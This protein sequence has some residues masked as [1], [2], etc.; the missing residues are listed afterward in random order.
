MIRVISLQ[1]GSSGNSVYVEADGV[2]ILIDAGISARQAKRR[3]AEYG[4][5]VT[6]CAA[7]LI[8]HDHSDHAR[9][10]GVYHRLFGL[11]VCMT[12][13][14]Y[15]AA[16]RR[17]RLGEIGALR[18]FEAGQSL[19]L[20][21]G[22]ASLWVHSVPTPHDGAD[23]VTFVVESGQ[24]RLGIFSDLGHV[25]GE[26]REAVQSVDAMLIESNYDPDMLEA[27]RYPEEL[28]HRI[29]GPGGHLS[30][31]ESADLVAFALNRN[32]KLRWA[33]LCHLSKDNNTP[34]LAVQ[35]HRERFGEAI[36]VHVASRYEASGVWTV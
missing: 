5:D 29:R 16:A 27:G 26:L 25:F 32:A 17:L 14:T 2:A 35:T 3:L 6:R 15:D 22:R 18:F 20:R 8:S 10:A 21:R 34:E 33:A 36:P 28:K 7:L 11:P 4:V 31:E 19:R 24:R 23:C 13:P 30:N 12:E 1:S 9:H